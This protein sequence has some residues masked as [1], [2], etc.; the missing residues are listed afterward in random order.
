MQRYFEH[1]SLKLRLFYPIL[2]G[3]IMAIFVVTVFTIQKSNEIIIKTSEEKLVS[4]VKS[5]RRMFER[6][7][8][9]KLDKVK[10]NLKVAH[11]IL[12]PTSLSKGSGHFTI[13]AE[14]Q[15][16]HDSSII[17]LPLLY[18]DNI[19][20]HQ[21]TQFIE[22]CSHLFGGTTTLFQKSDSGYVRV[23]TNVKR[24]DGSNARNTYIPT[25]SNVVRTIEE[26]ATYYGRAYVVDDW[27]ITAYEPIYIE[28]ELVGMLYV[29]DKEKD[30]V[31]LKSILNDLR[32]GNSGAVQVMEE[33]GNLLLPNPDSI[34]KVHSFIDQVVGKNKGIFEYESPNDGSPQLLAFEYFPPFKMYILAN[35]PM[36]EELRPAMNNI[37]Y[38]SVATGVLVTILFSL[39]VLFITTGRLQRLLTSLQTSN[40]KLKSTR[41][42]LERTEENFKALFDNSSDEIFVLD[43][44]GNVLEVNKVAC[45]QLGYSRVEFLGMN[46]V[47]IKTDLYPESII[48]RF[49]DTLKNQTSTFD[50][51]HISRDGQLMPV[52]IKARLIT[53]DGKKVI[54]A[55]AR[56]ISQRQELERKVLSVVIQTEERERERFSKDMHDG[57]GP[58]LSSVK[59]YVNEL[60]D[61]EMPQEQKEEYINYINELIDEAVSSTRAISNNLMPRVIHDYGL[62]KAL[63]SFIM[64]INRVGK[65]EIEMVTQGFETVLDK[66]VQLILFRVISELINNTLKHAKASKVDIIMKRNH[67]KIEVLFA[68]NGIGFD[69]EYVMQ[70]KKTGIGLKS[71]ISR[72][73]S[74]N[75]HYRFDSEPGKGFKIRIEI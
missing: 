63:D 47:D 14:N 20:L 28:N 75:G 44:Q 72:I 29:G 34:C 23:L 25:S 65:L 71:I 15:L 48:D 35:L 62:V 50:S 52:E 55:I 2:I 22:L 40:I 32:I 45:D 58:L 37:L 11:D 59:L 9:L 10:S 70:N 27:Y 8:A 26:G 42:E 64:K 33:G 60:E 21:D 17:D 24:K 36:K 68:D 16:S 56:D 43:E 57:L 51:E 4:E 66:N 67:E 1:I 46:M 39:Y 13:M 6:E 5:I 38:N 74:I 61:E 19:P 73:R 12:Q 3:I 54:L 53:Y 31:K 18:H 69:A 41:Q 7:H 30:F 49:D